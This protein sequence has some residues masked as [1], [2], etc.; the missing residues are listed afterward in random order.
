MRNCI[1]TA[2]K[3]NSHSLNIYYTNANSL[4]N[5]LSEL[6]LIASD[7]QLDCKL[8]CITETMFQP[9]MFDAEFYIPI[10]R[11]FRQDRLHS[12]GG[13]SCIYVHKSIVNV[14]ICKNFNFS[15]CIAVSIDFNTI[16]LIVIVLYRS[17]SLNFD[18]SIN[19]VNQLAVFL[20]SLSNDHEIIIVGDFN[21]PNVSWN[22]GV[23][24]CPINTVNKYFIMQSSYLQFFSAFNL[25]WVLT[26][27]IITRRRK[28]LNNIQEAT[29]DQILL[30]DKSLLKSF[31][32]LSGLRKSD[33]VG[34]IYN[35]N[36]GVSNDS[37][38]LSMM[39]QNWSK[40]KIE[41]I[42]HHG[43]EINWNYSKCVTS[44]Y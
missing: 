33:H 32:V 6:A 43:N 26:D 42:Q 31:K 21:L 20:N 29:L 23:V 5:K 16:K 38:F 22:D 18:E 15:D 4:K 24:K 1:T 19:I 3:T 39:N 40:F 34:L 13:G 28:V 10:F 14:S 41:E 7:E 44:D 36:I 27:D 35:I 8:L 9:D 2:P 12:E 30:S 37:N 11:L 17:P 25:Q